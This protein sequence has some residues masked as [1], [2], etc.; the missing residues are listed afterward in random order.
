MYV[1]QIH[2]GIASSWIVYNSELS[3]LVKGVGCATMTGYGAGSSV[4]PFTTFLLAS[5]LLI[6]CRLVSFLSINLFQYVLLT[7][8]IFAPNSS[9]SV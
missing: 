3:I 5:L 6:L 8:C 7:S 4:I 9:G 2:S 1:C